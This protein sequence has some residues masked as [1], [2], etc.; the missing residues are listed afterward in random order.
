MKVA[1][2]M[3]PLRAIIGLDSHRK[4]TAN[5]GRKKPFVHDYTKA[6]SL[7][8]KQIGRGDSDA[9]LFHLRNYQDSPT[10]KIFGNNTRGN[11]NSTA[12][13]PWTMSPWD[14]PPWVRRG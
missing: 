10:N 5:F 9:F 13:P 1:R 14:R 2:S 6:I 11:S 8:T 3:K 7:F 12:A 4:V